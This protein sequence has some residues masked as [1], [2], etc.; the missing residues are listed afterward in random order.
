MNLKTFLFFIFIIV[1]PLAYTQQEDDLENNFDQTTKEL[2]GA[3]QSQLQDKLQGHLEN[4]MVTNLMNDMVKN[5]VQEFLKENPFSKMPREEVK[6]MIQARIQGLPI[7]KFLQKHPKLLE[8]LVD[9]LRDNKAL[10]K[11]M[12]IVN[13][14]KQVKIYGIIVIVVFVISFILN[15]LNSKGN[16]F[17]RI[18]KK[19]GIFFGAFI[20]NFA[21]FFV[22]FK[23]ELGPTLKIILKYY[24][25]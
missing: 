11:I 3:D 16:L 17:K 1:S 14:P 8:L 24:H 9:W 25:W 15:L 21:A 20:I 2:S 7:E 6:S 4:N 19:M 13:K 5:V 18:L 22:L 23:D 10:P 12:G